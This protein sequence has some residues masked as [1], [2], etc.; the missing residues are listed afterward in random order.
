ME[1]DTEPH[2]WPT[3]NLSA[4]EAARF[5]RGPGRVTVAV[6]VNNGLLDVV[7]H[8]RCAS[9][10]GLQSALAQ[11]HS[12]FPHAVT[13]DGSMR[14]HHFCEDLPDAGWRA[15]WE[16]APEPEPE[17]AWPEPRDDFPDENTPANDNE[18]PVPAFVQEAVA[19]IVNILR[20]MEARAL[21]DSEPPLPEW[22]Q[23]RDDEPAPG[24][25]AHDREP[26]TGIDI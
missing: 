17:I 14:C 8:C 22:P 9:R 6:D 24:E 2:L 19:D 12:H 7:Y 18:E 3:W 25:Q 16:L 11:M 5:Y 20:N 15:R 26:D 4:E 10:E 21:K 1:R 23:P 13:L